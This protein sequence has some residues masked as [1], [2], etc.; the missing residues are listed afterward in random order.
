[1]KTNKAPMA[2]TV[3]NRTVL[4][5]ILLIVVSVLALQFMTKIG[6][7][8]TLIAVSAFLAMA[9]NPAVSWISKHLQS[10]SRVAAT[11]LAYVA[12][13]TLLI[14]FFSFVIP[15]LVRQT[16]DFITDVPST[17]NEFQNQ[18]STLANFVRRY[19]LNEQLNDLSRDFSRRV[20]PQVRG[21]IF[22]TATRIGSTIV[23]VITVLVLTF[24]MLVEG[25]LW[26]RRFWALQPS[27]NREHNKILA[28]KMYRVVTG[29]VNGQLLVAIRCIDKRCG[30]GRDYC[31]NGFDTDDWCHNWCRYSGFYKPACLGT[32]SAY[33][34]NLFPDISADRKRNYTALHTISAK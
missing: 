12:V 34:G 31:F 30:S 25:P 17:I 11:G 15:P 6:H 24:M 27:R 2:V 20:I 10:R 3:S 19:N 32:I 33:H 23:S 26:I 4:R 16:A 8:L 14:S 5:I 29:Y 9:L 18:D 13:L 7:I 21:E 28:R 22:S 1:M